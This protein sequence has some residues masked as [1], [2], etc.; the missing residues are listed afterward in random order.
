MDDVS[1]C[2]L[3]SINTY[4]M[5]MILFGKTHTHTM[6]KELQ[7]FVSIYENKITQQRQYCREYSCR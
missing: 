7:E 3:S 4:Y 2:E 5:S 1:M 6:H